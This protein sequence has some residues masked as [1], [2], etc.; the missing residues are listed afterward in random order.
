MEII[1]YDKV[2]FGSGEE[3]LENKNKYLPTWGKSGF[4][5]LICGPTGCGKTNCLLNMITQG[6]C[7][8]DI[9]IYTKNVQEESYVFLQNY[10]KK[11]EDK[12]TEATGEK[13]PNFYISDNIEEFP[14]VNEMDPKLYHLIIFDDFMDLSK[15]EQSKLVSYATTGRKRNCGCF[16]LVQDFFKLDGT[17]RSNCNYFIIY[18]FPSGNKVSALR[19]HIAP[20]IDIKDFK[21]IFAECIKKPHGFLM[22]DHK[23]SDMRYRCGFSGIFENL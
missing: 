15:K 14:D 2:I 11:I 19:G 6:M 20:E 1:N 9:Y 22:I 7:F 18:R 5:V 21:K 4:R 16:F 12:I 23:N 13:I 3:T 10:M 8:N 17:I